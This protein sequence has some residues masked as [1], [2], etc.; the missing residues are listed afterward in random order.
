MKGVTTVFVVFFAEFCGVLFVQSAWNAWRTGLIL[1]FHIPNLKRENHSNT[2]ARIRACS[3]KAY[4]INSN[5][6]VC[7]F[8][9]K[10]KIS[11]TFFVPINHISR[12]RK[13]HNKF[14][15]GNWPCARLSCYR[16][17]SVPLLRVESLGIKH[18]RCPSSNPPRSAALRP[19]FFRSTMYIFVNACAG[20]CMFVNMYE[21]MLICVY[22]C[23]PIY[24]YVCM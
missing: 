9:R 1:D 10:K 15:H 8:P 17:T 5:D 4:W 21:S 6:S 3:L 22:V 2:R 20:V 7:V 12:F 14:L 16:K 19:E 11:N 24:L 13:G 23:L 18:W